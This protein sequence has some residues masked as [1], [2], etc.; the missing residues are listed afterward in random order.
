MQ[1]IRLDVFTLPPRETFIKRDKE[2]PTVKR[3]RL[4][5]E[6][7]KF[8]R[9]L[10]HKSTKLEIDGSFVLAVNTNYIIGNDSFQICGSI[11]VGSHIV[12]IN[13]NCTDM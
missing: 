1:I 13:N 12:F 6:P 5:F 7:G 4:V 2:L 10:D 11:Y 3:I 9:A 8:I